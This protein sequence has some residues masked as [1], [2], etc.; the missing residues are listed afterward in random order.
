MSKLLSHLW[1]DRQKEPLDRYSYTFPE[2]LR[3][4]IFYTLQQ[5]ND[6]DWGFGGTFEFEEMLRQ[7]GQLALTKFGGLRRPVLYHEKVSDHPVIHHFFVCTDD[8]FIALIELCF[9]SHSMG[10]ADGAVKAVGAINQIL[11]EE[12]VGYELTKPQLV[13][14][15]EPSY[16]RP[17]GRNSLRPVYPQMNRKSERTVHQHAVKPALEVLRDPR[18]A[19]ANGELLKAFEEVR[20]GEYADGITSCGAAFE[21]VLRTIFTIKRWAYDDQ[22]D[23]CSQLV[24]I[25]RKN[26]LFEPPYVP[27]LTGIGTIR[28]K[29]GDAHGKGPKPE[30]KADREHAEH[31]IA[32]TC[33]HISFLI[34]KAGI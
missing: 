17:T 28:N 11:E 31:M 10:V 1:T 3:K 2:R 34:T 23:A 25:G 13:D 12:G 8:E 6:G 29:F 22:K 5:H 21:S 4:R 16:G 15:G 7:V 9:V 19:I 32:M 26:S 24:E 20:N 33:S 30:Y 18:F 27:L 14:S